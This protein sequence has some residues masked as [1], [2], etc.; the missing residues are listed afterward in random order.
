MNISFSVEF[1]KILALESGTGQ[2]PQPEAKYTCFHVVAR[3]GRT[4]MAIFEKVCVASVFAG[5]LALV[6]LTVVLLVAP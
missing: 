5:F 1:P 6:G 2:Q 4:G 3:I